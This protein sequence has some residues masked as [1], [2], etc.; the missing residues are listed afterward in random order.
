MNPEIDD[1]AWRR[2]PGPILLIAGP[3]TGKTHQ[4]ALRVKD[5][6][7]KKNVP[8]GSIT[9]ITFTKDAA[10]NM[11]RRIA[12][13]GKPDVYITPERRPGRIATMHSLGLE[14]I[15]AN[16]EKLGLPEDFQLITGRRLRKVL[17]H[18]AALLAGFE[19][20]EAEYAERTRQKSITPKA[21]DPAAKILE[22]YQAILRANNAIDYDDQISLACCLLTE[23]ADVLA[24]YSATCVHLLID[25]Y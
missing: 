16:R 19:E 10:E 2:E 5:L 12:D 25:E 6:V 20:K 7:E 17:F 8:P 14:I 1:E 4:L 9:V 21:G 15:R 3:G 11:R 24:Q 18:D 13:E 23:N 22:C